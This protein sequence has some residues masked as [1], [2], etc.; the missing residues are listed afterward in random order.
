[1]EHRYTIL[2]ADGYLHVAIHQKQRRSWLRVSTHNHA[3]S[4]PSFLDEDTDLAELAADVATHMHSHCPGT[5]ECALVIP[6]SW[7]FIHWITLPPDHAK[8]EAAAFA[9]EERLSVDVEPLTCAFTRVANGRCLGVGVYTAPLT[10]LLQSLEQHGVLV[11]SILVDALTLDGSAPDSE[12]SRCDGVIL[13][14]R[15]RLVVAALS[16]T[17]HNLCELRNIVLVHEDDSTLAQH[18]S[19]TMSTIASAP[20]HWRILQLYESS[21]VDAVYQYVDSEDVQVSVEDREASVNMILDAVPTRTDLLDLRQH[22]LSYD[23]R[24]RTLLRTLTR[25]AAA[26]ILLLSVVAIGTRVEMAQYGHG[27]EELRPLREQV[28]ADVFPGQSLPPGAALRMRSERIKLEGLTEGA[29]DADQ[30]LKT[31]GRQPLGLLLLITEHIPPNLKLHVTQIVVDD[32]N[33]KIIGQTTDHGAAGHLVQALNEMP[34]CE[35]DPPRTKLRKDL[36]VEFQ[37]RARMR[38]DG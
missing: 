5:I 17:D 35:V 20:R 27:A 13:L 22:A 8:Y 30:V 16:D 36:T 21:S 9:L 7:C 29:R 6:S 31:N 25:C 23:G 3:L 11:E 38:H 33:F 34:G 1:M 2:L 12:N 10:T 19:A 14:D 15:Q 26:V 24:W 37:I 28:Y 32:T 18:L 4:V